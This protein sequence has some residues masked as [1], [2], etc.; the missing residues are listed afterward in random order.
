MRS[1]RV[2]LADDHVLVRQ[3]IKALLAA[4]RISVEGEAEDGR[5]LIRT[6]KACQ[7]DIALVDV[8]MPLL[9]GIEAI[10]RIK[11]VA[12]GTRVIILSMF[13]ND[14]LLLRASRAGADG[15]ILKEEAPEQLLDAIEAVAAGGTYF[16]TLPDE[17]ITERVDLTPREREVLQLIAEGRTT[18]EV[19][20]VMTRSLYTVRNHRVRLMKKLGGRTSV[21]LV[22][23]AED[24]GLVNLVP[25]RREK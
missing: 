12:P 2:V 10:R 14:H 19:A 18:K 9:N 21:E 23:A 15:Y 24:L 5:S 25:A 1:I 22:Q 16:P 17:E 13:G 8:F 7:P 4:T 6:I 3:G 20:Q 11:Q